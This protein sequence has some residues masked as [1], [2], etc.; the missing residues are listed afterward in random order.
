[1]KIVQI[2]GGLGNQMF[3]YAFLI[4][5]RERFKQELLMD[6]SLFDT[7]PLHNGFELDRIFNITSR[8]ANDDEIHRLYHRFFSHSYFVSKI[9]RH[10]FPKLKSEVKDYPDGRYDDTIMSDDRDLYYWGDWQNHQYFDEYKDIIKKEFKWK[11][12]LDDKNKDL[13]SKMSEG[14]FCSIHVR[15]GD[16]VNHPRYK[17]I[18]D[19][20]YYKSAISLTKSRFPDGIRFVVFSNDIFWCKRYLSPLIND[21]EM[22]FIDWNKGGDSY[23]DMILMANCNANIIANSS[24]SW[25]G[26]YLN[27]HRAPIVIA[28]KKW[29]NMKKAFEMTLPE[30]IKI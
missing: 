30:W 21:K 26:A 24:F 17:G 12:E 5:L 9:Y 27:V 1:M 8:P 14:D 23:K 13:I 29:I 25:W 19:V 4:A 2:L 3:Q 16:Y 11:E 7:Y 15:R 22:F 28:P 6:I 20:D 10:F 18:C